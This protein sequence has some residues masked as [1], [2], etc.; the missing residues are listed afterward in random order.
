MKTYDESTAAAARTRQAE[1]TK[2]PGS[3][4]RLEELAIFM[5]G[6]Q[7]RAQPRIDRGEVL[8]V[9]LHELAVHAGVG[10]FLDQL[11]AD[12][13]PADNDGVF[14]GVMFDEIFDFIGVR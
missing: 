13:P 14:N 6:W 9:R 3:L 5:A 7:G 4:G 10:E 8:R 2:P 1:L 11:D 12:E